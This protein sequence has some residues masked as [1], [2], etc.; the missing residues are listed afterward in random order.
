MDWDT[1]CMLTLLLW[2]GVPQVHT[3]ADRDILAIW[4]WK[5]GMPECRKKLVRHQNFYSSGSNSTSSVRHWHSGIRVSP[6]PLHWSRI[7]PALPS[8]GSNL[9]IVPSW[10]F[11]KTWEH[12]QIQKTGRHRR[13]GW[14]DRT[15]ERTGRLTGRIFIEDRQLD[16]HYMNKQDKQPAWGGHWEG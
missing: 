5:T 4:C 10:V 6:V 12:N 8:Y 1:P 13:T 7:S 14:K 3:A 11:V 16:I 2:K 9:T 15:K